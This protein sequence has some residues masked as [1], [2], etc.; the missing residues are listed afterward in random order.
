MIMAAEVNIHMSDIDGAGAVHV[1]VK[2]D[3]MKL[4]SA[5]ALH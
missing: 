4:A 2:D 3:S 5:A 1:G